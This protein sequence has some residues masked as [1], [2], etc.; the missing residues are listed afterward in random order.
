MLFFQPCDDEDCVAGMLNVYEAGVGFEGTDEYSPP[1]ADD[2]LLASGLPI[3]CLTSDP[4]TAL[5]VSLSDASPDSPPVWKVPQD[6][7]D[8]TFEEPSAASRAKSEALEIHAMV[9]HS[10]YLILRRRSYPA[11][12][13]KVNGQPVSTLPQRDDG[14]MAV[15]VPQGPVD[16]TVDWTTTPDVLAGRWLS[17]LSVFLLTALCLTEQ[18]LARPQLS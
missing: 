11:W 6:S 7:C 8:A 2:S 9:A 12:R 3:A 15:P 4:T 10:G 18:K 14:L 16:L 13:V 17:A 1:G 5:G